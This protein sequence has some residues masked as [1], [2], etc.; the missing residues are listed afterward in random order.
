MTNKLLI[1]LSEVQQQIVSGGSEYQVNSSYYSNKTVDLQGSSTSDANGSNSQS[2]GNISA[3][4]TY[5]KSWSG[6]GETFLPVIG[7]WDFPVIF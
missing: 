3:V 1:D 5:S 6:T 2:E 4:T 7:L